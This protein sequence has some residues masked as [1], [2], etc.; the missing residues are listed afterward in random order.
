MT[1]AY[2]RAALAGRTPLLLG[3]AR[4]RHAA[5][6]R[7]RARQR[8]GTDFRSVVAGNGCARCRDLGLISLILHPG[9]ILFLAPPLV[10]G[11]SDI[12]RSWRSSP[13]AHGDGARGRRRIHHHGWRARH[14]PGHGQTARLGWAHARPRRPRRRIGGPAARDLVGGG[15]S[16]PKA[17]DVTDPDDCERVVA[18]VADRHGGIRALVNCANIAIWAVKGS[19][20]RG[21]G[22]WT[23]GCQ[24]CSVAGRCGG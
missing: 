3:C 13:G 2:W 5:G 8:P 21:G 9:N 16:A 12:D 11:D 23:S 19:A 7:D 1:T 24:P 14:R 17:L 6:P 18:R 20:S 22:R 10:T 15:T 4:A